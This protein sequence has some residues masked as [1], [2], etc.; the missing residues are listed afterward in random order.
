MH[1]GTDCSSAAGDVERLALVSADEWITSGNECGTTPNNWFAVDD[2]PG[3]PSIGASAEAC[4]ESDGA[5][6]YER[7]VATDG[8]G[9]RDGADT[10]VGCASGDVGGWSAP[11]E[12][13]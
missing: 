13:S 4:C 11:S 10:S 8:G 6:E 7:G 3:N 9:P 12:N 2:G 5:A 1:A